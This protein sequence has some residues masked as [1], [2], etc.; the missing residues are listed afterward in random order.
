[1][2]GDGATSNPYSS[3][4][5]ILTSTKQAFKL[6]VTGVGL[7]NTILLDLLDGHLS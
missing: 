5:P 6:L 1:M 3:Y 2:E 7:K 4:F